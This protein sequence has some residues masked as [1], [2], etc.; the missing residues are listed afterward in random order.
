MGFSS[1]HAITFTV[2]QERCDNSP[3]ALKGLGAWFGLVLFFPAYTSS[4]VLTFCVV[5]E[6]VMYLYDTMILI[7]CQIGYIRQRDTKI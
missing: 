1:E 6:E 5:W 7:F 4:K 3:C 2:F